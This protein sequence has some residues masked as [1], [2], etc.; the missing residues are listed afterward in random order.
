MEFYFSLNPTPCN[1]LIMKTSS[2]I[3][4]LSNRE[5]QYSKQSQILKDALYKLA[6]QQ[7]FRNKRG[8]F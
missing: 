4:K 3:K 8:I 2:F 7:K 6:N 1:R 5:N